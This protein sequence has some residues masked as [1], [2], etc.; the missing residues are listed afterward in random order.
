MGSRRMQMAGKCRYG[1]PLPDGNA[2][3]PYCGA[4]P[5][6]DCKGP[7]VDRFREAMANQTVDRRRS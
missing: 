7:E 6:Q 4:T 2:P 3:C 1:K 5:D